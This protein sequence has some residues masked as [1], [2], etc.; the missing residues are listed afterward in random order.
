GGSA[1][2]GEGMGA[3]K[4]GGTEMGL[5]WALAMLAE[6]LGNTNRAEEALNILAEALAVSGK[7]GNQ[8][9]DAEIYRLKGELLLASSPAENRSEAESSFRRAIEIAR[10]QHAK[11]LE[12]R[13][14]TSLSRLLQKQGKKD[15]ARRM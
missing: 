6:V 1:K 8:N 15:E 12:L 7:T 11:S 4:A 2:I 3:V 13:A 14:V 9:C 5:T 10:R